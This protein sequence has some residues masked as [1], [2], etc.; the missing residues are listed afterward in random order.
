MGGGGKGLKI[1]RSVNE[2]VLKVAAGSLQTYNLV[3]TLIHKH[4]TVALS[5]TINE[6]NQ[7]QFPQAPVNAPKYFY[8]VRS[9]RRTTDTS[10]DVYR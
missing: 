10:L 4:R 6:H 7:F 3:V 2:P 5:T 8:S 1:S 9:V